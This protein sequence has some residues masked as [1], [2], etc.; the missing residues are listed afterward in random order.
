MAIQPKSDASGRDGAIPLPPT[1]TVRPG[2]GRP[3]P[4]AVQRKMETFFNTSFA[5]VRIHVG[6]EAP[7]IGALAFTMGAHVFFAPGQYDPASPR[8]LR[9]LGHELTHVVQQKQGRVRNPHGAG[10]VIVRD[11]LLEA[12]ADRL[13]LRAAQQC[14]MP[15]PSSAAARP[16]S[17]SQPVG[18]RAVQAKM[19]MEIELPIAILSESGN[20]L[21]QKH[22]VL[23]SDH[24]EVVTD[25][26]HRAGKVNGQ[27]ASNIE[28]VMKAFDEHAPDGDTVLRQRLGAIRELVDTIGAMTS[29]YQGP[30]TVAAL[31]TRLGVTPG[32]GARTHRINAQTQDA[33]PD[34]V[35]G[36]V[37]LTVGVDLARMNDMARWATAH[38]PNHRTSRVF[39]QASHHDAQLMERLIRASASYR[40][41]TADEKNEL[42]G[43]I[44]LL[45]MQAKAILIGGTKDNL[46]KNNAALFSRVDM[47]TVRE[48][49][50][51]KVRDI[52][53]KRRKAIAK[54]VID[55]VEQDASVGAAAMPIGDKSDL[56]FVIDAWLGKLDIKPKIQKSFTQQKLFGEMTTLAPEEVGPPTARSPRRGIPVEIRHVGAR[57]YMGREE[58]EATAWDLFLKSRE[59]HGQRP[60]LG[61]LASHPRATYDDYMAHRRELAA[62]TPEI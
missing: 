12:E 57:S 6:P 51:A 23:K 27:S 56:V 55:A 39:D 8:G 16:P 4:V 53:E 35:E 61:Q 7:A 18:G 62:E 41:L 42:S 10:L 28:I 43:Y 2:P 60:T 30:V 29:G 31:A 36:L 19:G 9:L 34:K 11:G 15:V 45:V 22:T 24:Y 5:D 21:P 50:S 38:K 58:W 49:L 47:V 13:G 1:M 40:T 17:R 52:L 59:L 3:L 54:A 48:G 20:A 37:H 44:R 26:S 46:L 14:S 33:T 25:K 32:N